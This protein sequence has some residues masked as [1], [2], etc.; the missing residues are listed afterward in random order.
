M[1]IKQNTLTINGYVILPPLTQWDA[2]KKELIYRQQAPNTFAETPE[3]AWRQ[4]IRSKS[5]LLDLPAKIQR[6]HDRGWRLA[7]ARIIISVEAS[8]DP[9]T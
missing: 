8:E 6:L 1:T 4:I 5:N 9:L 7:S 3:L 2:P